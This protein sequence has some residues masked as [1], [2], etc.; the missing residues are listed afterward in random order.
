MNISI[1]Q[2][3]VLVT[4]AEAMSFTKAA[5]KLGISQPSISETIRRVENELG[6]SVFNR[7]TR[8]LQLTANG[9]RVIAS[10]REAV[11]SLHFAMDTIGKAEDSTDTL[12]SIAAL[13]SVVCSLL[14]KFLRSFRSEMPNVRVDV[15]DA[16]QG[17]AT[18]MVL[19]GHADIAII[20]SPRHSPV[21][22]YEP[23]T[24]DRM[25]LVCA[26][27]DPLA[28][29]DTV[30]WLELEGR[31]FINLEPTSS[32]RRHCDAAFLQTGCRVEPVF[33]VRQIPSAAALVAAGL[34]VTALPEF[35][36]P[37]FNFPNVVAIP[38]NMPEVTRQIGILQKRVRRSM[39]LQETLIGHLQM[40]A[41]GISPSTMI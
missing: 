30:G 4:V 15:F 3:E 13:P 25:H 17:K 21:F 2:F 36:L 8:H 26:A 37:M 40:V 20:S 5:Q 27:D 7:T 35:T 31:Q 6:F 9:S 19:E 32:V 18:Q 29:L 1:R 12:L 28:R 10:A 16:D 34:G 41:K 33:E 22:H 11:K 24:T 14:P 23:I 38:L 39:S